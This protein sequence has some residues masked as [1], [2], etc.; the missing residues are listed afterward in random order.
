MKTYTWERHTEALQK[1]EFKGQ[2][3]FMEIVTMCRV[4][5]LC[6]GC[7]QSGTFNDFKGHLSPDEQKLIDTE[8]NTKIDMA[9][10]LRVEPQ[11]AQTIDGMVSCTEK[12][13]NRD[14]VR[15]SYMRH[16]CAASTLPDDKQKVNEEQN[17][18]AV[19]GFIDVPGVPGEQTYFNR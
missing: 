6:H 11:G 9:L 1:G 2:L 14:T 4:L 19:S 8:P 5:V 3:S 10:I 16:E 17:I 15:D 7:S 12:K 13:L 18:L